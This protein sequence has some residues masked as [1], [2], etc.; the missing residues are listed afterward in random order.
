VRTPPKTLVAIV[1]RVLHATQN[2]LPSGS[3]MTTWSR[4]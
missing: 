4:C 3:S 2:S 1:S